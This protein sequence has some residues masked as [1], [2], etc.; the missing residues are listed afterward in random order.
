LRK[1][2]NPNLPAGRQALKIQNNES[3]F[4]QI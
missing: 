4:Y 2:Q 3:S 1:Y